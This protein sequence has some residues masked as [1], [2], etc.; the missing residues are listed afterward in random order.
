MEVQCIGGDFMDDIKQI[1]NKI[2][3]ELR[4]CLLEINTADIENV[5]K[6]TREA[7]NIF[8]LGLGRGGLVVKSFE[9]RLA[10]LG[11]HAYE[12][13]GINTPPIKENELLIVISCSGNTETTLHLATVAKEKG[14][15]II[16]FSSQKESR[17]ASIVDLVIQLKTPGMKNTSNECHSVQPMNTLFEQTLFVLF[18]AVVLLLMAQ[19]GVTPEQTANRHANLE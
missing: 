5:V 10:H 13:W 2:T 9:M 16:A 17:I 8:V 6:L 4:E 18:D 7:E 3:V 14:A 1:L 12:V 11:K 19:L 15:K